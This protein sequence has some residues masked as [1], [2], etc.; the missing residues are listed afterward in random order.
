MKSSWSGMACYKC[1]RLLCCV[2]IL[3]A[4]WL[5]TGVFMMCATKRHLSSRS[6]RCLPVLLLLLLLA[7]ALHDG[8][9]H[10]PLDYRHHGR[11]SVLPRAALQ[12]GLTDVTTW[13]RVA[14]FLQC[15]ALVLKEVF[16]AHE[17]NWPERVDPVTRHI[18]TNDTWVTVILWQG[19][20]TKIHTDSVT[21]VNANSSFFFF[22]VQ[23]L[24]FM[25]CTCNFIC[26]SS[27]VIIKTFS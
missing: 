9:C 10:G 7:L 24:S 6:E 21:Y 13:W 3:T 17:L 23:T 22:I 16:T 25:H 19:Y 4:C 8:P 12:S 20:Y 5:S 18:N 2:S 1:G 27:D 11:R 14:S 26:G 15:D